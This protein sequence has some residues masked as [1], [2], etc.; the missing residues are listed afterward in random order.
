MAQAKEL[1]GNTTNQKRKGG[2]KALKNKSKG[3]TDDLKKEMAALVK[4][5]TEFIK[6][7]KLNAIEPMKKRKVNWPSKEGQEQ[8][9]CALDAEF[10][11]KNCGDLDQ[12]D[13]NKSDEAK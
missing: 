8:E 6:K 3:E 2:N 11:K 10:K 4:K 9:L 7:S 1:K 12:M 5:A 13:I